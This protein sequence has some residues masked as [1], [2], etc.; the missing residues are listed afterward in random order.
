MR[1][2]VISDIGKRLLGIASDRELP[3]LAAQPLSVWWK[4]RH[5]P[6]SQPHDVDVPILLV[7]TFANY[8]DPQIGQALVFLMSQV[9]LPVHIQA[10]PGQGCCGRPAISKGM[11]DQAKDMANALVKDLA[12]ILERIPNARFMII[13]P[14]CGSV[15]RDDLAG[16]VDEH[17][18]ETAHTIAGCTL[19][20]EE[21]LAE[22]LA[23]GLLN[24][25]P[26]DQR[27]RQILYHGH[28]HQKALWGTEASHQL[29]D[30]IPNSTL[31]ELDA[32]CC[33]MAGSFGYERE[34]YD[35]SSAIAERRL[36]PAVRNHPDALVV[37][38]GT[39]CREQ[40][41]HI[42]YVAYHPIEALA[43]A[44]GWESS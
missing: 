19:S 33:G 24:D 32:G 3:A 29:L 2:P 7:D 10:M 36:W 38:S 4:V 20:V 23:D 41:E 34:H 30:A 15:L 37:A 12:G 1:L 31:T 42:N 40:I 25:L 21:W 43:I 22:C 39:S 5:R 18:R 35:I 9:N 17:W 16:L 8:Y 27:S 44:C 28:C 11:L 6:A 26:W 14:S 13:E